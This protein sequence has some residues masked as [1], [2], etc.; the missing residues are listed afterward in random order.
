MHKCQFQWKWLKFLV[1]SQGVHQRFLMKYYSSCALSLT[2]IVHKCTYTQKI[3]MWIR[4]HCKA[5]D[6]SFWHARSC[7]SLVKRHDQFFFFSNWISDCNSIQSIWKLTSKVFIWLKMESKINQKI[8]F[9]FQKSWNILSNCF[10]KMESNSAW[11]CYWQDC[12]YSMHQN[13]WNYLT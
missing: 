10:I 5:S 1:S 2:I 3:M 13:A 8:D 12:V 6:I 11:F 4:H 9:F 7:K